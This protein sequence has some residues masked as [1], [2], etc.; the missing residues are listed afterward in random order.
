[1]VRQADVLFFF[2]FV[3]LDA[4][5]K[6]PLGLEWA[7]QKSVSLKYESTSELQA[8]VQHSDLPEHQQPVARPGTLRDAPAAPP[9]GH[10]PAVPTTLTESANSRF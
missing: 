4:G 10:T 5:P 7:I 1:M 8:D 3:T 6:R 2:F 9:P